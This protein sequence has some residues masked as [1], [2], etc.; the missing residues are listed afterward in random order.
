MT[1]GPI[2]PSIQAALA[3]GDVHLNVTIDE[4]VA[5]VLHHTPSVAGSHRRPG[6]FDVFDPQDPGMEGIP[7][8]GPPKFLSPSTAELEKK[9]AE[10]NAN[11]INPLQHTSAFGEGVN[12]ATTPYAHPNRVHFMDFGAALLQLEQGRRVQRA[13][14]DSKKWV[15]V[16]LPDEHSKMTAPYFYMTTDAGDLSPWIPNQSDIFARDWSVVP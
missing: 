10:A 15:R 3:E 9:L 8:A 5:K 1:N 16:Q 11:V 13:G 6:D 4:Q 7:L 12:P 2:K 14:W